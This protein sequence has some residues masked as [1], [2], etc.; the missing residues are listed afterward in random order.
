MPAPDASVGIDHGDDT[1]SATIPVDDGAVF[2]SDD[3]S[4]TLPDVT[5]ESQE[6][7][8]YEEHLR[9]TGARPGNQ[10]LGGCERRDI[11]QTYAPTRQSARVCWHV[12]RPLGMDAWNVSAAD[13]ALAFQQLNNAFAATGI[14]VIEASVMERVSPLTDV[15]ARDIDGVMSMFNSVDCLNLVV[16]NSIAGDSYAGVGSFPWTPNNAVLIRR[17][18]LHTTTL[19]HEVGHYLGLLHTHET[20]TG[21]EPASRTEVCASLPCCEA[22]GDQLCDTPADRRSGCSV[23]GACASVSCTDRSL[24]PDPRN[25]MSYYGN[26]RNTFSNE[27]QRRM[28]CYID[29]LR[30]NIVA[31]PPCPIG[32]TR[33]A[34]ACVDLTTRVDHCG[35]CGTTCNA[36]GAT[37]QCVAGRCT[38]TCMPGF[39]NCDGDASN[40]CERNLLSDPAN[41]GLCRRACISP[42]GGSAMCSSGMCVDSN[43]S[44]ACLATGGTCSVG[45][46]DC[47][48]TG[49]V[50][51][52]GTSTICAGSPGTPQTELCDGRDN[53]CDGQTDEGNIPGTSACDTSV[54]FNQ[55]V[56]LFP[57]ARCGGDTEFD[58]HGPDVNL[59]VTFVPNGRTV[60]AQFTVRMR[61]TV[62]D[63]T[64]GEFARS[65][66][67]ASAPTNIDRILS[68]NFSATYRDTDHSC[69]NV[70]SESTTLRRS[71]AV[72][73]AMCVGDTSGADIC[74]DRALSCD[75]PDCAGCRVSLGCVRVRLRPF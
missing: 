26:C 75:R 67:S 30:R 60:Q 4:P 69:D 24:S 25:F 22:R 36:A 53:D 6:D 61:E 29:R 13:R 44:G 23:A 54:C 20:V 49:V 14:T 27:Q 7:P 46:G 10:E 17:T 68:D 45:V 65:I 15:A 47:R 28:L 12:V 73:A 42:S 35:A 33:C 64:C 34:G 59:A 18:S 62:A 50:S 11:W 8:D 40:G 52:R 51:C 3:G 2:P 70:F 72:S 48:R 66:V 71:D 5:M 9:I 74:S 16:V 63:W 32:Q 1:G 19:A 56:D 57:L 55:Q 31:P 43:C 38:F 39:A 41:C 37:S 58:G 21:T